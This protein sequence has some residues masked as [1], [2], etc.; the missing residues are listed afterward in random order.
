MQENINEV[1]LIGT[2]EEE[3]S[4]S[5]EIYG[6]KFFKIF[7][8]VSR[9][10]NTVD[11]LPVLVSDRLCDLNVYKGQKVCV[12]GEF[13][14]KNIEGE[15]GKRHLQLFVFAIEVEVVEELTEDEN[16]ILLEGYICKEVVYRNTP[17]GREISD[18]LLAVNRRYKTAYIPCIAWGRNARF[19]K[20]LEVGT[21]IEIRGR[22]QSRE[23]TNL[24]GE[25]KTA[26]ELSIAKLN[27]I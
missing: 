24:A 16:E 18:M 8:N 3:I 26:Y 17:L 12:T 5:H 1:N 9:K 14:S 11:R 10:S 20:D 22:I 4:F 19:C 21:K 6:E 2:F 15:D 25:N 23:Y 27:I 13:R 7:M